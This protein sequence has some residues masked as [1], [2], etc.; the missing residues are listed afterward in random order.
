MPQISFILLKISWFGN[1]NM[2]QPLHYKKIYEYK[3][4]KIS[5]PSKSNFIAVFVYVILYFTSASEVNIEWSTSSKVAIVRTEHQKEKRKR[6][7]MCKY[8][9]FLFSFLVIEEG[10]IVSRRGQKDLRTNK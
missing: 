5:R 4:M 8:T 6:I 9:I 10:T 2:P 3:R 7:I 1:F